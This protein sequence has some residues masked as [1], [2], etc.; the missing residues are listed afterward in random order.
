VHATSDE[1]RGGWLVAS[2]SHT[3]V[4]SLL[5]LALDGHNRLLLSVSAAAI[6][7]GKHCVFSVVLKELGLSVIIA[8]CMERGG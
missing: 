2:A 6:L 1:Q 8:V 4:K 5:K 7:V 3:S